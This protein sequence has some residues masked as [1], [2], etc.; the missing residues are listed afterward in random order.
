M[1]EKLSFDTFLFW[2]I[3]GVSAKKKSQKS[4]NRDTVY[5][6]YYREV[7]WGGQVWSSYNLGIGA[8]L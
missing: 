8:L 7:F 4:E 5:L 1:I 3:D 6:E 2:L